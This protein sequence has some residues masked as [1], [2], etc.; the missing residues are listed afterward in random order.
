MYL[1]LTFH[2]SRICISFILIVLETDLS[3]I[4]ILYYIIV[5]IAKSF[6]IYCC[7]Q[8]QIISYS[9]YSYSMYICKT[10]CVLCRR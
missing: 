6:N 9:E 10:S 8:Y 4:D 5:S 2:I 7:Y 3:S 1:V